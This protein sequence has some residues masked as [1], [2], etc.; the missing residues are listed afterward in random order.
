L[1]RNGLERVLRA[2]VIERFIT[3]KVTKSTKL[4]SIKHIETFVAFVLFVVR[5]YFSTPCS[6]VLDRKKVDEVVSLRHLRA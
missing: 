5:S 1:S 4:K 6:G 2:L 3:T